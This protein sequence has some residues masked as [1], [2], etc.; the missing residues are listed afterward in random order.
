MQ[1]FKKLIGVGLGP[2]NLSLAALLHGKESDVFFLE[3]KKK[4]QWHPE[5]MFDD[6]TMQ[7]TYLKDLVTPVD[8]TN[9]YSFLNYLCDKG[10]FYAFLNTQRTSIT[11]KEYQL[12]GQWVSRQLQEKVEYETDVYAVSFKNKHFEIQT[13]KGLWKSQ[14]VSVAT[15]KKPWT[16]EFASSFLGERVFH[17]KSPQLKKMNLQGKRVVVVGG[18]QTGVEIFRNALNEKWGRADSLALI[19]RRN[20]LEPLDESA[21]ANEYFT[22]DYVNQFWEQPQDKKDVL[23]ASQKLTSDGNTPYYL[24][25]LYRDLFQLRYINE[26]P[27]NI[28]I[29]PMRRVEKLEEVNGEYKLRVANQF[30]QQDEEIKADIVILATGFKEGLPPVLEPLFSSLELDDKNRFIFNKN[31]SLKWNGPK[32]NKIYALNFSRHNHGI[33]DPQTSLM[34]WRSAIVIN[35][36]LGKEVY[37]VQN[38]APSFLS[39]LPMN[40]RE[41]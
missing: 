38:H 24:K 39:Y 15:G 18:G 13:N 6:S 12:Y 20:N 31:Y 28:N 21:F 36:F 32:E 35:D 10:L 14:S 8:P 25:E 11:R 3:K 5:I 40:T 37:R 7:T 33:I 9:P 22:P 23:V 4:F 16:P 34:A 17:A 30:T 26:D 1:N 41:V 29:L 27:R 19:S 2:S